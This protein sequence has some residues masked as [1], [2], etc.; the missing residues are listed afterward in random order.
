MTDDTELTPEDWDA[1]VNWWRG[2]QHRGR[3]YEQPRIKN[4][5]P[6]N[7][8][9]LPDDAVRQL[10]DPHTAGMVLAGMFGVRP[11]TGE[12]DPRVID[13]DVVKHIGHGSLAA[14]QKV[15]QRFVQMLRRQSREG[16]TLVHDGREPSE[17]GHGWSVRP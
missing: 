4:R 6:R 5:P 14:G 17:D 1:A 2:T 12:D 8:F 9:T 3:Y 10:G 7:S 13:P 11:Y 15:L 16:V